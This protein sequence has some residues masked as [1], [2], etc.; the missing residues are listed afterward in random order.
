MNKCT[1]RF[2]ETI[3]TTA[4][5]SSTKGLNTQMEL[6]CFERKKIKNETAEVHVIGCA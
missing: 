1:K 6:Q 2:L 4:P 3:R 5:F